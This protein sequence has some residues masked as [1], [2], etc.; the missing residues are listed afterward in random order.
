MCRGVGTIVEYIYIYIERE[1]SKF[2]ATEPPGHQQRSHWLL[3]SGRYAYAHAQTTTI[4]TPSPEQTSFYSTL[5]LNKKVRSLAKRIIIIK[6]GHLG[7]PG[8]E[9]QK[10][11]MHPNHL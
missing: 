6:D 11:G 8:A 9:Q 2:A 7:F 10:K 5:L 3:Q 4:N 1:R